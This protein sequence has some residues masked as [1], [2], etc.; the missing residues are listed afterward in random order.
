MIT[1][2]TAAKSGAT[3]WVAVFARPF[4]KAASLL[5]FRRITGR[6]AGLRIGSPKGFG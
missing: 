1:T 5:A 4:L 2:A 3:S 6:F